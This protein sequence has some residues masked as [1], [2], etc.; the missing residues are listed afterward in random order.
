[1][2]DLKVGQQFEVAEVLN[3]LGYGY[4]KG[5]QG[6]VTRSSDGMGFDFENFCPLG[7]GRPYMYESEIKPVGRLTVTKL[8]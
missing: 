5:K 6:M 2:K 8:K 3:N 4:L 1:M 7:L